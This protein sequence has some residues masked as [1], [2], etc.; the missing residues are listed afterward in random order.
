M[1]AV[2]INGT[3]YSW[4]SITIEIAG[5]EF[6]AFTA[7]DYG[8][9]L[10]ITK[11]YGAGSAYRPRGR[12]RG[13]YEPDPV[14]LTGFKPELQALRQKLASQSASGLSYG[15]VEFNI[16]V[17][18]IEPAQAGDP[19]S[20]DQAHT[21]VLERCKWTTDASSHSESPDPLQDTIELDTMG[22]KRGGLTLYEE[23]SA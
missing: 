15:S 12:T 16:V 17:Q 1:A 7:I 14:K 6:N 19:A 4:A 22:V 18:F 10:T 23:V 5:E 8:D 20:V 9:K 3:E 11:S 2:S 21:V 13:K